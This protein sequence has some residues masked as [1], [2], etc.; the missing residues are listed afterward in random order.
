MSSPTIDA[1]TNDASALERP[2]S[3]KDQASGSPAAELA[4]SLSFK[5]R[6]CDR[7]RS[8]CRGH[9]EA[10][11]LADYVATLAEARRNWEEELAVELKKVFKTTVQAQAFISW[12]RALKATN[13]PKAAEG[14]ASREADGDALARSPQLAQL[15]ASA[16]KPREAARLPGTNKN[17]LLKSM[18]QQLQLILTKLN[19]KSITDDTKEKYQ[20][21]AHSIKTQMAK[22]TTQPQ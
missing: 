8:L 19:D 12:V 4:S 13:T 16:P 15:P 2:A 3:A 9:E 17:E 10:A 18:T 11:V 6:I 5:E 7:L 21:L 14:G 20:T 1:P 22:I